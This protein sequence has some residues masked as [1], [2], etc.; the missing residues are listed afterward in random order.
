MHKNLTGLIR[1]IWGHLY[2]AECSTRQ[3]FWN[4]KRDVPE[5]FE[6]LK[7]EA[8]GKPVHHAERQQHYKYV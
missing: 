8:V 7:H 4:E 6:P 1:Y 5:T 2:A 3:L